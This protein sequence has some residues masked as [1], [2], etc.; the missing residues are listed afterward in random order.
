M[1][2]GPCSAS[3]RR[4][5]ILTRAP[6]AQSAEASDLKSAQS[7][8]ESQW[9]HLAYIPPDLQVR[10]VVSLAAAVSQYQ[11]ASRQTHKLYY[12]YPSLSLLFHLDV[13]SH[14]L[15]FFTLS[16]SSHLLSLYILPLQLSSISLTQTLLF[17]LFFK[18]ST[19]LHLL[20]RDAGISLA[21][22]YRYL[23]EAIDSSPTNTRPALRPGHRPHLAVAV[24]GPVRHARAD[25]AAARTAQPDRRRV[26]VLRKAPPSRRQHPGAMRPD[27]LPRVGLGGEPR[28]TH[29]I[30]AARR[31]VLPALYP[32]AAAE[33]PTLTY[34]G[35]QAPV[36]RSGT[37]AASQEPLTSMT[38]P[39][40][41]SSSPCEPLPNAATHC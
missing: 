25:R 11:Y 6:I 1:P 3:G 12:S 22:A 8:F 24:R 29:D 17:L 16:I 14:T 18:Y 21:T 30:T 15:T 26:L 28:S 41:R 39:A 37:R 31:F 34:K 19:L 5:D 38:C 13:P 9:G 20:S 7:G 33:T 27:R 40:T 35:Y 36:S 32:A 4:R 10:S 2:D 23:H